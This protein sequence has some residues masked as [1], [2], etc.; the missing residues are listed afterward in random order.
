MLF[1][2][3]SSVTTDPKEMADLLQNQFSSV[4]SNPNAP[5]VKAATF[6]SPEVSNS[7]DSYDMSFTTDDILEAI[8]ELKADYAIFGR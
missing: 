4:Y 5:G 7:F 6:K 3:D 8:G 2:K 1:N